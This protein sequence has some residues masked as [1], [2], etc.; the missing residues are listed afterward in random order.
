MILESGLLVRPELPWL[1]ASLDGTA[2][3]VEG[4]FLR[5]IEIKTLKEGTRLTADEL[6]EINVIPI[7][8]KNKNIK[9]ILSIILKCN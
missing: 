4:N 1:S 7:L 3:D 2:M 8:D 5:N 6:T 9:K